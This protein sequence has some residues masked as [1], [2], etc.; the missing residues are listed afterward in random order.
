MVSWDKSTA[1]I[2]A[3]CAFFFA[4]QLVREGFV[5]CEG[6]WYAPRQ[7]H[8]GHTRGAYGKTS[9]SPHPSHRPRCHFPRTTL[10]RLVRGV[11]RPGARA[12]YRATAGDGKGRRAERA[13]Q[14]AS[15]AKGGGSAPACE[16]CSRAR[17]SPRNPPRTTAPPQQVGAPSAD[18][19]ARSPPIEAESARGNRTAPSATDGGR[20]ER[21]G[22]W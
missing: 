7:C 15:V 19:A 11:L 1:I 13:A 12:P 18:A 9:C 5:R 14:H 16:A 10:P 8:S 3:I 20:A 2:A 22:G 21:A 4:K 6:C 17:R